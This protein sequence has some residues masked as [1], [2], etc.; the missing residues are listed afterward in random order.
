MGLNSIFFLFCFICASIDFGNSFSVEDQ[1][2]FDQALQ[3]HIKNFQSNK[4][5]LQDKTIN[6]RAR[7][8]QFRRSSEKGKLLHELASF[9]REFTKKREKRASNPFDHNSAHPGV[10]INSTHCPFKQPITCSS[11]ARYRLIIKIL[12]QI[13]NLLQINS[14]FILSMFKQ[15]YLCWVSNKNFFFSISKSLF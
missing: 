11:T 4:N 15:F 8:N 1:I 14:I 3:E 13:K 6:N 5:H 12:S 7:N 10:L 9:S 2:Q